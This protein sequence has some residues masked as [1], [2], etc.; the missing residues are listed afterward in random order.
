MIFL[1][2]PRTL[3]EDGPC[4]DAAHG[5]PPFVGLDVLGSAACMDKDVTKRSLRDAGSCRRPVYHTHLAPTA[6][7]SALPMSKLK[8]GLLF[9]KPANQ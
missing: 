9:V 6:R 2:E 7:S 3:G 5:D 8:L 4:R 1:I